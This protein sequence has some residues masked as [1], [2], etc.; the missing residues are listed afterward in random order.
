MWV[1]FLLVT[2]VA[3]SG[4]TGGGAGAAR[5]VCY[6]DSARA[7]GFTECTHLVYAGDARGDKLDALLKEYRKNNSRLKII[8]RVSEADKVRYIFLTTFSKLCPRWP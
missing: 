4:V 3:V 6:A 5:F 7:D 8:L 2:A 1:C